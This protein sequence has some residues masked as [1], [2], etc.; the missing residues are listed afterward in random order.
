MDADQRLRLLRK[1]I[2]PELRNLHTWTLAPSLGTV[3]LLLSK[4][5][6]AD[7]MVGMSML[8]GNVGTLCWAEYGNRKGLA[9]LM[10][11]CVEANGVLTVL[12]EGVA[13]P[14]HNG[15]AFSVS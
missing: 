8:G 2:S 7:L 5:S 9:K 4:L 13:Q 12:L 15:A 6:D 11:S 10:I 14:V 3:D 1:D